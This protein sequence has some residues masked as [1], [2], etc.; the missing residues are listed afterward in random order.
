[1]LVLTYWQDLFPEKLAA[2]TS[3]NGDESSV[4][5]GMDGESDEE[6]DIDFNLAKNLLESFK[7]QAGTAGPGGNLLGMMGIRLPRDDKDEEIL[8]GRPDELHKE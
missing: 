8:S 5:R 2:P 1:M 6:V 3:H 7:S 4:P